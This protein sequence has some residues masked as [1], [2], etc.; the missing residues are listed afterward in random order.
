MT[1]ALAAGQT[2]TFAGERVVGLATGISIAGTTLIA[3][4]SAVAGPSGVP[5]SLGS[6]Y[7]VVG[8]S[9]IPLETTSPSGALGG[10]ISSGLSGQGPG[11]GSGINR[12]ENNGSA[13][14]FTGGSNGR[15]PDFG[16]ILPMLVVLWFAVIA[17]R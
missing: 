4:A 7:L 13:V 5:I 10:W 11:N 2:A 12:T 15:K 1:A 16:W 14:A 8:S 6:S 9:T 17:V 3:G